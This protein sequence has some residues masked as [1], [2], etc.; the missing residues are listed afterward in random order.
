MSNDDALF[1][2]RYEERKLLHKMRSPDKFDRF[3]SACTVGF[4]CW[5]IIGSGI[6][7]DGGTLAQL[8]AIVVP[9]IVFHIGV[10]MGREQVSAEQSAQQR[11][12]QVREKLQ[13][14]EQSPTTTE[15]P[16]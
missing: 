10:G 14:L 7:Y 2:L 11:L 5:V 13:A 16:G 12:Q 4:C 3:S 1:E 15:F 6:L 9:A 8:L